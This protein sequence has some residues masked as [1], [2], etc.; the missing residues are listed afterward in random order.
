M[1]ETWA[2][3]VVAGDGPVPPQWQWPEPTIMC[4]DSVSMCREHRVANAGLWLRISRG[5]L[6]AA[7]VWVD[8]KPGWII[9]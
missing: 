9:R 2:P 1:I 6:P 3:I 5:E 8:D 4:R 7:E